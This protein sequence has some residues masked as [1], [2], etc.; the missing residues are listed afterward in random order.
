MKALKQFSAVTLQEQLHDELLKQIKSG[1]YPPGH[2]IPSEMQLSAMYNICLLYTS[3][4]TMRIKMTPTVHTTITFRKLRVSCSV[5]SLYHFMSE[6][7][8]CFR[9]ILIFIPTLYQLKISPSII[10]IA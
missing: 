8:H 1:Q 10:S 5:I 6:Y 3:I 2:R 4:G 9:F 7:L